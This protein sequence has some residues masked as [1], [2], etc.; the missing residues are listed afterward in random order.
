MAHI[1]TKNP[2]APVSVP[3]CRREEEGVVED[4]ARR[5]PTKAEVRR[6]VELM[7]LKGDQHDPFLQVEED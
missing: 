5:Q 1:C 4:H 2:C 3:I 6:W 7:G